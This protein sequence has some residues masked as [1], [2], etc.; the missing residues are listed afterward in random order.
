MKRL[1]VASAILCLARACE[2]KP[3]ILT[4]DDQEQAQLMQILDAATRAGGLQ[5]APATVHFL[6]R[7]RAAPVLTGEH[8]SEPPKTA[9][10]K[11]DAAP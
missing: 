10:P 2:A 8:P 1:L 3:V 7:L 9:A 5:I 4:L 11:K 6:D